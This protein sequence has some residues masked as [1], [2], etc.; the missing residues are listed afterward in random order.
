M[1][2]PKPSAAE[3]RSTRPSLAKEATAGV[4][5]PGNNLTPAVLV[6][7]KSCFA[8]ELSLAVT[9]G[10]KDHSREVRLSSA[11]PD[12]SLKEKNG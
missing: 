6:N 12:R 5:E 2:P 3:H 4:L 8:V 7:L 1:Q 10:C 11:I 9:R